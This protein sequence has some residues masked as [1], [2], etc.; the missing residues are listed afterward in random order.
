MINGYI[1][2]H[3]SMILIHWFIPFLAFGIANPAISISLFTV[4][5]ILGSKLL[6]PTLRKKNDTESSL[7]E[8]SFFNIDALLDSNKLLHADVQDNT[9]LCINSQ[10]ENNYTEQAA[11]LAMSLYC[12][13]LHIHERSFLE[14]LNLDAVLFFTILMLLL[15]CPKII[16]PEANFVSAVVP[17]ESCKTP[18]VC[19]AAPIISFSAF[20]MNEIIRNVFSNETKLRLAPAPCNREANFK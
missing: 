17:L 10:P 16:V 2:S 6:A 12:R 19:K 14:L 1:Q 18:Q 7:E 4:S 11:S 3:L 13:C 9:Y 8:R 5:S 15:P 20:N